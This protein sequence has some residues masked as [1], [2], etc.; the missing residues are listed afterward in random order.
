[1]AINIE[2]GGAS[3]NAGAW[4]AEVMGRAFASDDPT[5]SL[6]RFL[7]T[8]THSHLGAVRTGLAAVQEM[9]NTEE[10]PTKKK[11]LKTMI[12]MFERRIRTLGGND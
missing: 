12:K 8:R 3:D 6:E 9:F 5:K 7:S 11:Q 2:G 4:F 10:N 1:M